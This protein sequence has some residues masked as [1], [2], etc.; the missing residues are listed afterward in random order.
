MEGLS[1]ENASHSDATSECQEGRR[2]HYRVLHR[3]IPTYREEP[4]MHCSGAQEGVGA[5]GP[6]RVSA[7]D[8][9]GLE[10][11]FICADADGEGSWGAVECQE[12][13]VPCAFWRSRR[14]EQLTPCSSAAGCSL[15]WTDSGS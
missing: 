13:G 11:D 7:T 1:S 8:D 5:V 2:K 6:F 4:T 10:D 14:S 12:S 3:I 9:E 15:L